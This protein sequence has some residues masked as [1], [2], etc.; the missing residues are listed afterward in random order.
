[1][2]DRVTRAKTGPVQGDHVL[3]LARDVIGLCQEPAEAILTRSSLGRAGAD[4]TCYGL[5]SQLAETTGPNTSGRRSNNP[6]AGGTVET[7]RADDFR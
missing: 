2:P 1:V 5:A 6:V 7:I 4:A 3:E